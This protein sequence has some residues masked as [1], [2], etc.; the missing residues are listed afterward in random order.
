MKEAQGIASPGQTFG[1]SDWL[2]ERK[3]TAT[4]ET[5]YGTIGTYPPFP[6]LQRAPSSSAFLVQP[7]VVTVDIIYINAQH[8]RARIINESDLKLEA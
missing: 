7:V 1:R 4:S 8:L 3:T 6:R 2:S 5:G